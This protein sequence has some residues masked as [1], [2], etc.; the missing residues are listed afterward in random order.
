MS[1]AHVA[2]RAVGVVLLLDSQ[3]WLLYNTLN[4]KQILK[5]QSHKTDKIELLTCFFAFYLGHASGLCP[6][7]SV[8]FSVNRQIVV[9]K[10]EDPKK[11]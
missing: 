3:L 7:C 5:R 2:Q 9:A 11:G 6:V 1:H 10:R 8:D 4:E